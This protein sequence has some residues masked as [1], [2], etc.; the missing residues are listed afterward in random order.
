MPTEIKQELI[1]G[2]MAPKEVL[3]VELLQD[4]KSYH[5]PIKLKQELI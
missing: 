2:L 5:I 3:V 1:L 4:L